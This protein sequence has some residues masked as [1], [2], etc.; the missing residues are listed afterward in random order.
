MNEKERK[1]KQPIFSIIIPM[2]NAD[3][4]IRRALDSIAIQQF[5]DIQIIV[6]DDNSDC[7]D[8]SKY[9]VQ[10]WKN[11]HPNINLQLFQTIKE[12]GGPG[13]ARNIGL[14]NAIGKYILFLDADDILNKNALHS[15]KK[16]ID[17]NPDT[18]IFVLGYQ[19]TR[20]D[21]Y[22]NDKK[23]YKLPAGKMQESRLFQI[24]ANTAGTIWNTCIKS[25]LFGKKDDKYK[26]RFKPNCK[27][28]DL[29]TKVNLFV[30]NKK[31]IKSV[32]TITHTQF[33]RRNTSITGGLTLKDMR[34][35]ADAHYEI[36]NI[37]NNEQ[38]IGLKDKIYID[39]RKISFIGVSSWLIQKSFRNKLDRK[40][41]QKAKEKQ[42]REDAILLGM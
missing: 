15:I 18:D 13:G 35:L 42:A 1:Q 23:T 40:R 19:L 32:P 29:P 11:H 36:A 17:E 12:Q 3:R 34:R 30:R 8:I 41:Q 16:S 31:R 5:E 26:I 25:D 37:K 9:L 22:E 27:F 2:K 7:N 20:C 6:I 14:D 33:S 10:S 4:Y 21:S 38:T 24:G 39:V 28:E